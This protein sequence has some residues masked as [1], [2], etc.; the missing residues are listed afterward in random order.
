MKSS[1]IFGICFLSLA[2]GIGQV[3]A[4]DILLTSDDGAM[5]IS[6]QFIEFTDGNYVIRTTLGDLVMNGDAVNC[7][8]AACPDLVQVKVEADVVFAGAE[9]VGNGL[10]PLLLEG[11]SSHIS[12]VI[13]SHE[14]DDGAIFSELIGDDGFGDTVGTFLVNSTGTSDA[15]TELANGDTTFGMA[16]RRIFREEARS[17]SRAGFGRMTSVEQEHIIAVD[18][19][20]V[21]VHPSNPVDAISISDLRRIYEGDITN[22]STLGG[23]DQKIAVYNRPTNS[24][25]RSVFENRIIGTDDHVLVARIVESNETTAARI[26][27]NPAALGFVSYAYLNGA[28]PLQLISECNIT[29]SADSFSAK[30]EEYPLHRRLYLYTGA[31]IDTELGR[32]FLEFATS[33]FADGVVAKAGYIDLG[34][35]RLAQDNSMDRMRNLIANTTDSF[36]LGLMRELFVELFQWDRLSTTFR[37][38]SGSNKLERKSELDLVRL[39]EYLADQPAGTDVSLVGFTDSDGAVS[40][41]RTLSVRRAE[42][43]REAIL[44]AGQGRLSGINFSAM[45]FGELSPAACNDIGDGKHINRRVEVWIRDSPA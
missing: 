23:A 24:G 2:G 22:W 42:Q 21:I 34:I 11:F 12:S 4:Q 41:N 36:E 32:E 20:I 19:L 9:T 37:F 45:G 26:N 44:Q 39:V 27:A 5:S 13:E 35:T 29:T 28:K 10:L 33:S 15:F 25:T 3:L 31:E 7:E 40:A 1:S 30:T 14:T 18:N 6:G 17:L 16:S 38:A 43:V 8:G